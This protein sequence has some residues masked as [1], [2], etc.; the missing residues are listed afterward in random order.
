MFNFR[1]HSA[2]HF[3]E[4]FRTWYG[5]V[6]K[7]FAGLPADGAQALERDLTELLNR[8]NLAG[9]GGLVI[10]SQYLEAVVTRR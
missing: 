9:A 6:Y 1:Y 2:A 7:A 4:V 8:S 5:P 10:P 3:I